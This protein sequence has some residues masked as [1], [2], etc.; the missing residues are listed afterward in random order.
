MENER[1]QPMKKMMYKR[2]CKECKREMLAENSKEE[3]CW[4]CK[5]K[6]RKKW[7]S[8]P[9]GSSHEQS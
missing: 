7:K 4:E 2:R 1:E 8:S 9:I 6:F 3:M 5:D